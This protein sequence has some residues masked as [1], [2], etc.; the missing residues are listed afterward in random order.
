[1]IIRQEHSY[2]SVSWLSELKSDGVL[3]DLPEEDRKESDLP[4]IP[5][6]KDPNASKLTSH[7]HDRG[8]V[9]V[10]Q[11]VCTH[12]IMQMK[13]PYSCTIVIFYTIT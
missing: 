3:S 1:M 6:G 4:P 7:L 10:K 11:M 2:I 12:Y 8:P 13:K 9:N 5:L